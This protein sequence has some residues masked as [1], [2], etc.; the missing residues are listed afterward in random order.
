MVK[1]ESF[2]KRSPLY[3]AL[4][5]ESYFSAKKRRLFIKIT[6]YLLFSIPIIIIV[7]VIFG[8]ISISSSGGIVDLL[9]RKLTGITM[10]CFGIFT[11]MHI[12]EAY[13]ASI[14]YFEYVAKNKYQEKDLYTFSAG[15]ILRRVENNNLLTGFL[16]SQ[17]IGRKIIRRLGISDEEAN[18]LLV[19]QSE[20]KD[21]PLFNPENVPL[22]KVADIINF[23]YNNHLD[24]K[25]LLANHGLGQKDLEATVSWVIY[26]IEADEYD[27]QW[28]ANE[29]LAKIPGV[30]TDW[31]FGH[32]YNLS[33][34]SRDL[35]LD[36]EVNSSAIS[37]SGRE[38]EL[39]QV[40]SILARSIGANVILVGL[41]GQEKMEV[42]W[43]LCR[44]IKEKT[45]NPVLNKKK[46]L[47]F[48]TSLFTASIDNKNNF[49]QKINT[50]FVETLNAG[51]VLLVIDNL[52]KLIIQAKQFGLNLY[53]I[54]EPYLARTTD[55]IIALADTEHFHTL[56][57]P[58]MAIMSRFETVMT[59]PLLL[60]EII[61]II[62]REALTSEKIY[63]IT[64]T[65]PAILE[66]AKS[67]ENYFPDGVSSDKAQDLLAEISPWAI[68]NKI[69]TIG[70]D[71]VLKYVGEKT[72]IP[73]STI[74]KD[75]K[76]KLLDLEN[77]LMKRVVA[78]NEAIFAVS[79]AL[80]RSRAGIRNEKRPMGSFLF[81][82][83]TGV[84]KTETAKALADIFFGDEKL[85]M[86][87][88]M[89]EY[90]NEE[91]LARLI[92]SRETN[93]QGI[94]ANMLRENPYGVLLLDEFEKTNKHVLNLFLQIIDEGYFSDVSGKKVMAR[95]IMFIATSNAGAEKIFEI[96]GSGKNLKDYET[97][98]ISSIVQN[99]ILKPE[100]L[101]RFDATILF[102]PL[103]K[104][105]L[106]EIA[107]LMLGKVSK[108]LG[109]KGMIMTIDK[110]LI[111]FIAHGGYNPTFG[112]R[113]MNR[114]IQNTV[115][116]H[117][118]DLI[119]RGE[120]SAGQTISFKVLSD[121]S[122]KASLKPTV[123]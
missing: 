40:Q 94:L 90:Q 58:D 74:S 80:R 29:K 5:L 56:I 79:N 120:F 78:Q 41:P 30:A 13:F 6:K 34:Y 61:K 7:S 10:I 38:R 117:L 54:L 50:I 102:H 8:D 118:A 33:R 97:E 81:L 99:G 14:Y 37:F 36:R 76:E 49:E 47:L 32:T 92:G 84:G 77:M 16:K 73:I 26:S 96:V 72:N 20:I 3:P 9:I 23:I 71:D 69:E 85:L 95:N 83:P 107:K 70:R 82:G 19:K 53:E 66:I 114:L 11:L 59:K 67:A 60:D 64:Y 119:I 104:E 15:R 43:N 63:E 110:E 22:I 105:N 116:Q 75:E 103:T 57:E 27:R 122:D 1:I 113:P 115:E 28:W 24:F 52:P 48:L 4:V 98:I 31:S 108:K 46:P 2:L 17:H 106:K 62:A 44:K 89:S 68:E 51:N 91:S 12:F 42:V 100:L 25:N 39:D 35:L 109:E 101:N 65:Y 88:D 86:R 55:Q 112:A 45:A 121:D 87:L 18:L 111:D 93:S 123:V 21:P